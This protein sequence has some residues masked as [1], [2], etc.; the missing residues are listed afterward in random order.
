MKLGLDDETRDVLAHWNLQHLGG[1][2]MRFWRDGRDG[3]TLKFGEA[4]RPR[5]ARR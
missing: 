1:A 3:R 2:T 5:K 4:S